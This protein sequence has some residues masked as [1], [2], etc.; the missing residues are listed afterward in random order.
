MATEPPNQANGAAKS[1]QVVASVLHGVKDLKIEY[2]QLGAPAAA[3]VQVAV[4]AT[5]LCGSDLH[6]FNHYR[7]GDIIVRE[8]LTLGHESSGI[9]TAVGADV[10]S[11]QMGDRVALEVGLPCLECEL[12]RSGRYNICQALRFRSSAKSY[13]HF[14]GTLQEK[15]NH[16]AVYCHKIPSS[17]S[18]QVGALLEP[19]GVAI[20]GCRRASLPANSSVLIFGAGAVGLLCAAVCKVYGAK[21]VVIA[22]IQAE[23]VEFAVQHRFADAK[24]EVPMKRP[25]A[26]DEK[27]AF[28]K[29]VAGLV[30]GQAGGEVDAVFELKDADLKMDEIDKRQSTR[31]GGRI[32]LI[33]M[34]SP[35]QTLPISAAALREIDLVGVFR[36]ANTYEEAIK[37]VTSSNALLPDLSKLVT[38]THKGFEG[39]PGAFAMAGRVKDD[40]GNLVLKVVVDT[41]DP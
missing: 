16:P 8:P 10:A 30:R 14:Q 36:Y 22:D 20:H 29:E 12:C 18:L 24:I 2:R 28:A 1:E 33:G 5:G 7:N 39:I 40:E 11:L 17:V 6:Y 34:G 15:I 26:I 19:L 9:V 37:L 35:I 4:Q 25:Q 31:P 38:Q 21:M 23:R 32:M 13:P 41:T 27:L 3:E